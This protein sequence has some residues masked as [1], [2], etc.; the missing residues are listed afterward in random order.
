MAGAGQAQDR[1][2]VLPGTLPSALPAIPSTL[3]PT[4]APTAPPAKKSGPSSTVVEAKE[5]RGT[6]EQQTIAE[7]DAELQRDDIT[8]RADRLIYDQPS[9]TAKALGNVT[10]LHAGDT[11]SGP[12]LQLEVSTYAGF[13]LSPTY[14]LGR[15]GAS[16]KAERI[17][18]IDEQR[19]I[20]TRGTYSTCTPDDE[21]EYPWILSARRLRLDY[22]KSEGVAEGGVLRF[23]GMPILAA[24]SL[25]F[26]L[27]SAR[28]S[29]WLPGTVEVDSRSGLQVS[30]PYYWNIAPNMDATLAPQLIARRG[31]GLNSQ[32]RYLDTAYKGT[33]NLNW[34]PTDR[35]A[36]RSRYG[37]DLGHQASLGYATQFNAQVMRVSD[38]DYW[39]DFHKGVGS[40]TPRLLP[41]DINATRASGDWA[42]YARV[43]SWQV[44]QSSVPGEGIDAPYERMPQIGARTMQSVGR[45]LRVEFEGEFNRFSNPVGTPTA[46]HP[47]GM[48]VHTLA[49]ISRPWVSPAWTLTPKLSVNAASYQM[50]EPMTMGRY[51]GGNSASRVIPTASLDSS[52]TLERNSHWF[53]KNMHQTLEPRLVYA[54]TPYRDQSGLPNF[55]ASPIDFNFD[56]IYFNNPFSGVDR[57]ADNHQITAGVS[58]RLID[59]DTGG[60]NMRLGMVQRYL[61]SDQRITPDSEQRIVPDANSPTAQ[62]FSDVFL[63]G[64]TNV[65]P[66]WGLNAT[67][68]YNPD[69]ARVQRSLLGVSYSPSTLRTVNASYTSDRPGLSEQI[70]LGWQWPLYGPAS[71]TSRPLIR[72]ASNA[73][74]ACGGTWY[75]VG[76]VSMNTRDSK[77]VDSILGFEY[78]GGCWIGR[79]VGRKQSTGINESVTGIGFQLELVGLSRLSFGSNPM[80]LLRENVGGYQPLRDPTKRY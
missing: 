26:P 23:M 17:D 63:L 44:L 43:Q 57:V 71:P 9:D 49:S 36:D 37:L 50:D 14:V 78:D 53:G 19:S 68:Q 5:I 54:Y 69:L 20:T 27:S 65:I 74:Q 31:S 59:P 52:W 3:P 30:A 66:H 4:A 48:R 12:E 56:S 40:L 61:L 21:G 6:P 16:G 64:S 25:S 67:M 24:P 32:F 34:L 15:T 28:K 62:R 79:I 58:T 39:K 60:E 42:T 10:V 38:N 8:I 76:R 45:G 73:G 29:G 51:A 77:V 11:F 70:S 47:T 2:A 13:F 7:G 35:L 80:Q 33:V 1:P 46:Q 75:T 55:D 41:T 18:F 22:E 72:A